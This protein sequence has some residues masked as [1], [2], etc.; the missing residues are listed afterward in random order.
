MNEMSEKIQKPKR[1][2][3]KKTVG[4]QNVTAAG[5]SAN[6]ERPTKA[7][8]ATLK[9]WELTYASREKFIKG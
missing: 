8:V 5:R 3:E 9:A 7:E 6:G 1:P 4:R 2:A